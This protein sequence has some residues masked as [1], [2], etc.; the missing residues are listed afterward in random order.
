MKTCENCKCEPKIEAQFNGV[1]CTSRKTINTS[2]GQK[3]PCYDE[4]GIC[5]GW[6]KRKEKQTKIAHEG[7]GYSTVM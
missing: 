4:N 3:L 5:S 7:T 6:V 1:M 2:T